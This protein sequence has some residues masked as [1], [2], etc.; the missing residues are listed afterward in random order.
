[1]RT[2][3]DLSDIYLWFD[4]EFT[5]LEFE[6]ARLLQVALIATDAQLARIMPPEKDIDIIVKLDDD[7]EI[8]PWVAENL[9]DLIERCRMDD[10]LPVSHLNAKIDA[11]LKGNFGP[12][13]K[14]ISKRPILAGNSHACDWLLA[15]K[16]IPSLIE[17]SNYRMLDVSAW[18]VHWQ[19]AGLGPA[20]EKE[21]REYIQS[22]LP[23]DLAGDGERHD[24]YFDVQA[25][26]AELFYYTQ[27]I[28]KL[29]EA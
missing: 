25:S 3:K 23:F 20:F 27:A 10:A 1:M 2:R 15:R 5:T 9:P 4:T 6:E 24:A 26:V 17:F 12:L 16:Y 19:N 22:H 13:R 14:D 29:G 11:W 18:K 7:A 28:K 8:S 21:D